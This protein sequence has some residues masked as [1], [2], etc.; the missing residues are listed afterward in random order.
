MGTDKKWEAEMSKAL[1][2]FAERMTVK[3]TAE[4][5]ALKTKLA[6]AEHV[7]D[8]LKAELAKWQHSHDSMENHRDRLVEQRKALLKERDALMRVIGG[9]VRFLEN[10]GNGFAAAVHLDAALQKV[11]TAIK[12]DK[13]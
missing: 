4:R 10:G 12:D 5:D 7:R 13:K 1:D 2:D 11:Q 8:G 6:E 3:I 9:E